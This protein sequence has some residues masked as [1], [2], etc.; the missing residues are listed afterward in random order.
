VRTIL[1]QAEAASSRKV[2]AGSTRATL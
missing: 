1:A 2:K